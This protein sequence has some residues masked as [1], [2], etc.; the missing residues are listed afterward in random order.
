VGGSSPHAP[1]KLLQQQVIT[2]SDWLPRGT[3]A[4]SSPPSSGCQPEHRSAHR[5]LNPPSR[6]TRSLEGGRS[7]RQAVGA[8]GPERRR[9]APGPWWRLPPEPCRGAV[10]SAHEPRRFLGA[11]RT[12]MRCKTAMPPRISAGGT[13]SIGKGAAQRRSPDT[14]PQSSPRPH[15]DRD[16]VG[17]NDL[18][19]TT[20]LR[21]RWSE[22]VWSFPPESNRRPHPYHGT[23]RN[24][25]ADH[26][27]P[28][29]CPT[30][31]AEVMGSPPAKLCAHL[32]ADRD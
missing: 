27:S 32:P 28:S 10:L 25:C 21:L 26:H 8:A 22:P 1:A 19:T 24:R 9:P 12:V 11:A 18:E 6:S 5:H 29:S 7:T 2:R 23:T 20:E 31:G 14:E 17:P 3:D 15:P 13:R 30:V 16:V 4:R